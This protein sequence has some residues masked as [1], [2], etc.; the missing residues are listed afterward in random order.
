M[1]GESILNE[2][3]SSSH[4]ILTPTWEVIL[5]SPKKASLYDEYNTCLAVLML[6]VNIASLEITFK[7]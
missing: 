5:K 2:H 3:S 7:P 6:F 1:F 4:V